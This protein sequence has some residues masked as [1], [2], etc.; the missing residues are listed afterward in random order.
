MLLTEGT[1]YLSQTLSLRSRSRISQANIPGSFALRCR[2][3]ST[4]WLLS[5]ETN[6]GRERERETTSSFSTLHNEKVSG[7]L[8]FGVVTRGLEPPIAPGRTEPVSLNLARILDTHPCETRSCREMSHGLTPWRD[9]STILI[10]VWVG[11]GRPL[12]KYPP[13]WFTSPYC[14]SIL[15]HKNRISLSFPPLVL[16]VAL[17]T[18]FPLSRTSFFRREKTQVMERRKSLVLTWAEEQEERSSEPNRSIRMS[19]VQEI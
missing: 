6:Q 8:T 2:M 15:V 17:G 14:E 18:L 11:R 10:R 16:L 12:T 7:Q 4:T 13:S 1:L 5:S 9:N 19:R 3:Y